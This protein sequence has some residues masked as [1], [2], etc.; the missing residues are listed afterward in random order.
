M[1]LET[2]PYNDMFKLRNMQSVKHSFLAGNISLT[3]LQEASNLRCIKDLR[4]K[5]QK[6]EKE[7]DD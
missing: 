4:V 2:I 6:H 7:E 3:A 5:Q 1:A